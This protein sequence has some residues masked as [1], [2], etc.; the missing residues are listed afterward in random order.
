MME[1]VPVSLRVPRRP[2]CRGERRGR[3]MLAQVI[4]ADEY[5]HMPSKLRSVED[6]GAASV[7]RDRL[8]FTIT[9]GKDK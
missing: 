1:G 8:R 7:Q 3:E 2:T 9:N 5:V 4:P 6:A